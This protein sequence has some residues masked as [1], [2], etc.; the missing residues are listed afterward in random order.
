MYSFMTDLQIFVILISATKYTSSK[1]MCTWLTIWW[2]A[3]T[4]YF[5]AVSDEVNL[6]F[7][8]IRVLVNKATITDY[9]WAFWLFVLTFD[10]SLYLLCIKISVVK[11]ERSVSQVRLRGEANFKAP[12]PHYFVNILQLLNMYIFPHITS[13]KPRMWIFWSK[14][15]SFGGSHSG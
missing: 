8:L 4:T 9:L 13:Q 15:N 14:G 6:Y 7:G 2:C 11:C 12:L 3:V 10:P 5:M 1:N